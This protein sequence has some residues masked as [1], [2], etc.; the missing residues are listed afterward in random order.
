MEIDSWLTG[1]RGIALPFTDECGPLS[2]DAEQGRSLLRKTLELGRARRWRWFEARGG[3]AVLGVEPTAI[4]FYGH[5]LNLRAGETALLAG[6]RSSVRQAIRK[7]EAAGLTLEVGTSLASVA[8]FYRLYCLTRRRHGLPPQPLRFFKAI[9]KHILEPGMGS[10]ILARLR[11]AC[12]A[13]AVF[14]HTDQQAMYKYAAS[15][16]RFQHTRASNLVM[17][18]G[19]KWYARRGLG[20]LHLGRTSSTN[21]GLRRFKLGW[22]CDEY[23]IEYIRY[24]FSNERFVTRKD[25]SSGW[26]NS[27]FRTA[28]VWVSRLAGQ[29]LYRHWG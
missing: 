8:E 7:A 1:R 28:P 21:H 23:A 11:G 12:V 22:G 10:V 16:E 25:E 5:L 13:A 6:V 15:D 19:I 26:H 9:H 4:T 17:W 20:S 29:M 14:F 24:D 18:T 3:R 2:C 27:L